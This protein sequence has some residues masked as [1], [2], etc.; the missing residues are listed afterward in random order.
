MLTTSAVGAYEY[1]TQGAGT[2]RPH[3]PIGINGEGLSYD[4]NGN[5]IARGSRSY[6]D[7]GDNRLT[8]VDGAVFFSYG[9][10][11]GERI[12]EE[13]CLRQHGLSR[14]GHRICRR[15]LYQIY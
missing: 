1:P 6:S 15:G 14:G 8:A 13:Q 11:G 4:G 3:T 10:D 7:D 5:L 9:P 12:K 2:V